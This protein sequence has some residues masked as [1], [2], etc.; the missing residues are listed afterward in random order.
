VVTLTKQAKKYAV[1]TKT[2]QTVEVKKPVKVTGKMLRESEK[3]TKEHV[4]NNTGPGK[5]T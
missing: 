4:K 5:K 3:Q 1:D 2:G